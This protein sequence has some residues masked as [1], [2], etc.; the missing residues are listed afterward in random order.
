MCRVS[1]AR[2]ELARSRERGSGR[3]SP[4]PARRSMIV[5]FAPG[6]K[7]SPRLQRTILAGNA[8]R[9]PI[10]S[11][12]RLRTSACPS[13]VWLLPSPRPAR[14]RYSSRVILGSGYFSNLF[15]G[16]TRHRRSRPVANAQGQLSYL[17]PNSSCRRP[18]AAEGRPRRRRS[19]RR[20]I[21]YGFRVQWAG[22]GRCN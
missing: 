13:F 22:P 20:K 12:T 16:G 8:S 14:T 6:R 5:A 11:W 7:S 3:C 1:G 21:R 4:P 18:A 2:T 19:R 15:L 10:L 17:A 9:S